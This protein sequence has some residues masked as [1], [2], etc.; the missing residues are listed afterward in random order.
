MRDP[1]RIERILD[2]IG[3]E[4]HKYPDQRLGQLIENA[5]IKDGSLKSHG[6][7]MTNAHCIFHTEDDLVEVAFGGE[8]HPLFVGPNPWSDPLSVTE[9]QCCCGADTSPDGYRLDIVCPKHDS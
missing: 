4:W 7:L 6:M 2:L 9:P 3:A 8:S 1:A 5:L